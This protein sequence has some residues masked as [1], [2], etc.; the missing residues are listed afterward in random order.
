MTV[1]ESGQEEGTHKR[2]LSPAVEMHETPRIPDSA[3]CQFWVTA[4]TRVGEGERSRVLTAKPSRSVPAK[5]A[6][7]GRKI[8]SAWKRD[9]QLP[10]W[11][12]GVPLPQPVW[13]TDDQ[14]VEV[15]GRRTVAQNGSLLLREV[16]SADEG[17]YTCSVENQHGKDEIVYSVRVLVP[18]EAP[19][20]AVVQTFADNLLLKWTDRK[21]GGSPV[22]GYVINYK[23]DHGDWEEL[24]VS[25]RSNEHML[26]N[27]RCGT[28]YL[29]YVTSFNRIGTGLP[30]DI[31]TT[32]T[33]GTTPVRPKQSQMLT[34]NSTV[35][36]IW[37]DS[38]GDGGCG[39]LHFA[40]EYRPGGHSPW[41][42]ASNRVKPTE[43]IFS[44][45]DLWPATEYQVKVV[46]YNNAGETTAIY[47]FTTLTTLGSESLRRLPASIVSRTFF[48]FFIVVPELSPPVSHSGNH[49]LANARVLVPIVLS[50]LVLLALIATLLWRRSKCCLGYFHTWHI[51]LENVE[52]L[53]S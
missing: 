53:S 33:E 50:V 46:A 24:Q 10:C 51:A 12:V 23:G 47:N 14:P 1:V 3:T 39:I 18:P 7:F 17:N 44:I 22:L 26:R 11:R 29:L 49:P 4:S 38:W 37:L 16:Q 35:A 27:L 52:R 20:L 6:S 34:M 31:V 28:K 9:V 42:P 2:V 21:D 13:K 19:L 41:L 45:G 36:T 5:V 8:V 30:S 40:V 25:A 32:R 48:F 43:R 15:G